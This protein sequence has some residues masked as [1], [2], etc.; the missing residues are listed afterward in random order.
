[1]KKRVCQ[2]YIIL[3]VGF[4]WLL[5]AHIGHSLADTP[6]KVVILPFKINAAEDLTYLREGLSD[7]LTSRLAWEGK[8][9]VV[10]KYI[11]QEALKG[12]SGEIDEKSARSIGEKL[13]A[14]Y[15]LFGSLTVIGENISIDGRLVDIQNQVPAVTIYNQ[16]K[17]MDTVMPTINEFITEINQKI[18]GRGVAAPKESTPLQ[19]PSTSDIHTHP[20]RLLE[21]EQAA[22]AKD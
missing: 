5:L 10:D 11:T 7:M 22:E 14:H 9:I 21:D 12:I 15:V 6:S 8:V 13:E 4:V 18:F 19:T 17:G 20:E 2:I 1:M 16:S 3:L